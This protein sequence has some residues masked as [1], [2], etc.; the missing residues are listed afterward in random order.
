MSEKTHNR[1]FA[2]SAIWVLVAR[3]LACFAAFGFTAILARELTPE[4]FGS[5]VLLFSFSTLAAL[6]GSLGLNRAI[7]K[8]IAERPEQTCAGGSVRNGLVLGAI[9]AAVVGL[10]SGWLVHV[11]EARFV[12]DTQDV[13]VFAILFGAIVSLR[14]VH[15][16]LAETCRGFHEKAW[17]NLFGG[18]AGGPVP[19]LIFLLLVGVQA[20]TNGCD[21]KL[22]LQL[23]LIAFGVT[24]PLL[25]LK[26][27]AIARAEDG[28][29]FSMDAG[30][31]TDCR[32]LLVLSI[33]LM[34]TQVGA[35]AMSQADIWLAGGFAEPQEIAV[36][37]A[38]Q[39]LLAFLSIPL[40]IAA[41]AIV[42]YIPQMHAKRDFVGLQKLVSLASTVAGLPG[43]LLG[44]LF[45]VVP[46]TVLGIAFGEYYHV[47]APLLRILA[48]G[49][50]ICI[51]T[52]PCDM[53]LMM[54]GHQRISLIVNSVA[55][56]VLFAV[57]PFAMR[58]F[59]IVGLAISMSVTTACQ[60]LVNW[61]FARSKI[62]VNT[63]FGTLSFTDIGLERK[64]FR[65]S[66]PKVVS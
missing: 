40:Q 53:L 62:G 38:A 63:A 25:F 24:F 50:L 46:E 5:F 42:S 52:G 61:Y 10:L 16:V 11:F 26:T 58:G 66:K 56:G 15:L 60:N 8:V 29:G 30:T 19:H 22:A 35:L 64:G 6:V 20:S 18:P 54:T 27:V 36:Y 21:L 3:F 41:T 55:T 2:S 45:L 57:A 33:P 12:F 23:Y 59:G 34:L 49:Q 14:T 47:A 9:G 48:V 13:F 1:K 51:M 7:V 4:E 37:G 43:L 39:R 28:S 31:G 65:I 44:V 32:A 17:S